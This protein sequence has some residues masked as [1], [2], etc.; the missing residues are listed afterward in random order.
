MGYVAYERVFK[1]LMSWLRYSDGSRGG[2]R[3]T[4]H[5]SYFLFFDQNE[6]RSAEKGFLE[7]GPSPLISGSGSAT[8]IIVFLSVT[9]A[10]TVSSLKA[11]TL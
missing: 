6:A 11:T 1:V 2:A 8:E 10:H 9:Y 3:G 7:T 4:R 5:P